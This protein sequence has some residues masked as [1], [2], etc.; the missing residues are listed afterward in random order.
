MPRFMTAPE[1]D[2]LIWELRR[3]GW[4]LARIARE[5]GMSTSGVA[6]ALKRIPQERP[7]RDPRAT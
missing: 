4:T 5:V 2:R 7:A 1:K 6:A 3:R